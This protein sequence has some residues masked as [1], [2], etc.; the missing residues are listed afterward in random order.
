MDLSEDIF[1]AE[2]L[3]EVQRIQQDILSRREGYLEAASGAFTEENYEL[4]FDQ[5][6]RMNVIEKK[7]LMCDTMIERLK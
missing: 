5:L 4:V 7:L 1:E 3:T 2:L 6:A